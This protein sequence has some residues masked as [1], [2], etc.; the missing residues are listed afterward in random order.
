[1]LENTLWIMVYIII[2]F[3]INFEFNTDSKS[4]NKIKIHDLYIQKSKLKITW[5]VN[6]QW[7]INI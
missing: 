2:L 1:M 7:M 5:L 4:Q 3:I 6:I